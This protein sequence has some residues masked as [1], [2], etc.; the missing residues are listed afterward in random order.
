MIARL[1][2]FVEAPIYVVS[3]QAPSALKRILVDKACADMIG[4]DV[5]LITP[6]ANT[7]RTN[8]ASRVKTRAV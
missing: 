8:H 5:Q 2:T 3:T 6:E 1:F 7:S 4:K